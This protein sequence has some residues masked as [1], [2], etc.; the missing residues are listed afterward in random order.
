MALQPKSKAQS[1]SGSGSDLTAKQLFTAA[2]NYCSGYGVRKDWRRAFSLCQQSADRGNLDAMDALGS[3]YTYSIGVRRNFRWPLAGIGR[4][5]NRETSTPNSI[6]RSV[7]QTG[8]ASPRIIL[9]RLGGFKNPF[10][11][12]CRRPF[13]CSA[14][15]IDLGRVLRKMRERVSDYSPEP[16]STATRTPCFRLDIA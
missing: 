16:P 13:T 14:D 12:G 11:R 15:S 7:T 10:G 6:S 8:T 5:R 3:F 1:K 9:K 4:P 2:M